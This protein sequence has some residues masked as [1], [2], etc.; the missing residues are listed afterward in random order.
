ML[1]VMA[2]GLGSILFSIPVD[3]VYLNSPQRSV[4]VPVIAPPVKPSQTIL[5]RLPQE[6]GRDV[7]IL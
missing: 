2:R 4:E 5:D 3:A 6:E 1:P 7:C